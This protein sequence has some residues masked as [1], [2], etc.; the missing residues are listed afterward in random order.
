[1]K[2]SVGFKLIEVSFLYIF[3]L[4]CFIFNKIKFVYFKIFLVCL[5]KIYLE[6]LRVVCILFFL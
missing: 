2:L 1:M 6:V 4:I 5:L 3:L